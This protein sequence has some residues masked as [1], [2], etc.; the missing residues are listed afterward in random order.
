M[1]LAKETLSSIAEADDLT[2]R[3]LLDTWN[4]KELLG[5]S[6]DCLTD[7]VSLEKCVQGAM[8]GEALEDL[9]NRFRLDSGSLALFNKRV[10]R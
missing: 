10:T 9:T 6:K 7:F 8:A 2:H 5:L 3:I 4:E 1:H